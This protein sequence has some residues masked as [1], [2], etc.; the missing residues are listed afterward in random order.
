MA[1]E[2][3]QYKRYN[4]CI[5][6]YLTSGIT[7]ALRYRFE[8][9]GN[10]RVFYPYV[11][12]E[13]FEQF[14]KGQSIIPIER[15]KDRMNRTFADWSRFLQCFS[16]EGK[17]D[18]MC[19]YLVYVAEGKAGYVPLSGD[20]RTEKPIDSLKDKNGYYVDLQ[21]RLLK[22]LSRVSNEFHGYSIYYRNQ[23]NKGSFA[24]YKQRPVPFEVLFSVLK[25]G[26]FT[27]EALFLQYTLNVVVNFKAEE[28]VNYL[29]TSRTRFTKAVSQH[30]KQDGANDILNKEW[31]LH[32]RLLFEQYT[33]QKLNK[34][35]AHLIE[36]V[37]EYC[38]NR[39]K[40]TDLVRSRNSVPHLSFFNQDIDAKKLYAE[41]V[42]GGFIS[43]KT[44]E[45]TF[46]YYMT[47]NGRILPME[48]IEWCGTNSQLIYLIYAV[49][50]YGKCEWSV[51]SRIFVSSQSGEIRQDSLRTSF[52]KSFHHSVYRKNEEFFLDLVRNL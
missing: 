11:L 51:V 6:S 9:V 45:E 40:K 18:R 2:T 39:L 30:W 47:G 23:F 32:T 33:K 52:Y 1:D 36:M 13:Q 43:A 49:E 44:S 17:V 12:E 26:L 7:G 20:I 4:A 22:D 14:N 10:A 41:L 24:I 48:K 15:C 25:S 8:K 38:N 46:T 37:L 50:G 34:K 27:K 5:C 28:V 16:P 42:K 29:D 3:I 21:L 31:C 19:D 35:Q